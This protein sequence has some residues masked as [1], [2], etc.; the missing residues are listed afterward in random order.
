M[1]ALSREFLHISVPQRRNSE[2][3]TNHCSLL[4]DRV[5]GLLQVA[6]QDVTEHAGGVLVQVASSFSHAVVLAPNRDVDALFLLKNEKKIW[7][8]V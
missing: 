5:V 1:N 8:K 7:G 2:T 6:V 3:I 4:Y